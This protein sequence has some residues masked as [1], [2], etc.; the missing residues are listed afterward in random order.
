MV[1]DVIDSLDDSRRREHPL[2]GRTGALLRIVEPAELAVDRRPM[3]R[4]VDDDM[5]REKRRIQLREAVHRYG[6]DD[7]IGVGDRI[8][9]LQRNAAGATMLEIAAMVSGFPDEES[10]TS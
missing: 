3:I 9:G 4:R 5:S 7:E 6:H 1:A 10:V 8:F 2:H